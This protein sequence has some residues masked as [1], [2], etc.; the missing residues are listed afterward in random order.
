MHVMRSW[1]QLLLL[2]TA[3]VDGK[4]LVLVWPTIREIAIAPRLSFQQSICDRL[5][6]SVASPAST[7]CGFK[8]LLLLFQM[9]KLFGNIVEEGGGGV[10]LNSVQWMLSSQRAEQKQQ[11]GGWMDV[12]LVSSLPPPSTAAEV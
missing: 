3:V 10:Q 11:V 9:R 1:D 4:G 2:C 12:L 5:F 6:V 8:L 7:Q